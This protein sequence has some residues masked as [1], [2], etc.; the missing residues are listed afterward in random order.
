V[1]KG[2]MKS[3]IVVQILISF[4]LHFSVRGWKEKRNF[5][6]LKSKHFEILELHITTKLN[7]S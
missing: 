2:N 5:N 3:Q 6:F 1:Y 4:A 7:V